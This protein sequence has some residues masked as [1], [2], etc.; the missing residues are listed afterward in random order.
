MKRKVLFV[1]LIL[2]ALLGISCVTDKGNN[3]PPEPP[4]P[5]PQPQPEPA[6]P[7]PPPP[8]VVD[9]YRHPSGIILEGATSY[10]VKSGDTLAGIA[11]RLYDDGS[12]YPLILMVSDGLITDPDEIEPD[13][14]L[15]IPDVGRNISDARAKDSIDVFFTGI[16]ILEEQ[17][18]RNGTA[19]LIRDHTK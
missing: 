13:M 4:Q 17:R 5:A 3:Q 18:G 12:F 15:T 8:Q 9:V 14:E 11:W 2:I 16:A 1:M 7:P 6:P 19:E 10:T